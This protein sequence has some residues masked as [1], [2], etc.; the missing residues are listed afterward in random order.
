[1][2]K[3]NYFLEI[4]LEDEINIIKN[5]ENNENNITVEINAIQNSTQSINVANYNE[6][7]CILEDSEYDDEIEVKKCYVC[8]KIFEKK[9]SLLWVSCRTCT[10]W[11]CGSCNMEHDIEDSYYCAQCFEPVISKKVFSPTKTSS[12]INGGPPRNDLIRMV[13]VNQKR[14]RDDMLEM[15]NK[16]KKMI[17][18]EINTKV[19]VL[20]MGPDKLVGDVRRV[21]ALIIGKS[22]TR[23]IFYQLLTSFGILNIKYRASDLELII[24]EVQGRRLN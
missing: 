17:D 9:K 12:P 19:S 15:N 7:N 5:N 10:N 23:D 3:I 13:R 2:I 14:A 18:Y 22:G 24:Y 4:T 1:M 6:E 16:R 21:P 20:S 11:Y 8:N